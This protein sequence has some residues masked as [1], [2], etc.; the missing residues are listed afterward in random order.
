M[1]KPPFEVKIDTMH[2]SHRTTYWVTLVNNATRPEN[3]KF[4]DET[5]L[6][7]PCYFED[8]EYAIH[9][10]KEWA[11]FLG[12]PEQVECECIM[13]KSRGMKKARGDNV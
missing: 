6:I 5:G 3:P 1:T 9:T 2:E 7:R 8:P 11:V 12:V 4:L 10:A 13:C